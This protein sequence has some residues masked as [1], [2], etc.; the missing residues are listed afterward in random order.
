MTRLRCLLF[1]RCMR[2]LMLPAVAALALAQFAPG[3]WHACV[4]GSSGPAAAAAA[5]PA[6]LDATDAAAVLDRWEDTYNP[7]RAQVRQLNAFYKKQQA[8]YLKAYA[9]AT[10]KALAHIN[11]H[12]KG[13]WREVYLR[14]LH[15]N[16][17]INN[18]DFRSY[19]RFLLNQLYVHGVAPSSPYTFHPLL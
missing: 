2:L 6:P 11:S 10:A 18:V 1:T 9:S 19:R 12:Y 15:K 17:T 3:A 16:Q 5:T 13:T 4:R 8:Q 7:T 14:L